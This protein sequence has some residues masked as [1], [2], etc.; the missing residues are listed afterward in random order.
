[1]AASKKGMSALQMS[2]MIGVTY[3]TAWFLCHRIRE[4]MDGADGVGPL[5]GPG[6]KETLQMLT[7]GAGF[8]P[9]YLESRSSPEADQVRPSQRRKRRPRMAEAMVTT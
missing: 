7:N 1:M 2:R 6:A 4:A 3:K 8:V 5:G 9:A